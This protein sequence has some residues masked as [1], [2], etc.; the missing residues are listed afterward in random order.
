MWMCREYAL[1]ACHT[2]ASCPGLFS[3]AT[4]G[5]RRQL[6][7]THQRGADRIGVAA[8]GQWPP[9]SL[10]S[11]LSL[12]P[13]GRELLR[14]NEQDQDVTTQQACKSKITMQQFHNKSMD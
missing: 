13:V 3:G 4:P 2:C 1:V 9:E 12:F 11:T 8:L 5:D 6:G 7:A 14:T 10:D